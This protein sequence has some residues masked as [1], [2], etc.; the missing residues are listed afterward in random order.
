M[1]INIIINNVNNIN[2]KTTQIVPRTL[3]YTK[4]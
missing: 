2:N 4:A 1:V 3:Q